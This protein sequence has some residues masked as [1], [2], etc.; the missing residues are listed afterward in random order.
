MGQDM[1]RVTIIGYVTIETDS[2]GTYAVQ[3]DAAGVARLFARWQRTDMQDVMTYGV[4]WVYGIR[5]GG[6]LTDVLTPWVT[7]ASQEP[8]VLAR[9]AERNVYPGGRTY[10]VE[11][12][13]PDGVRV[14]SVVYL[15]PHGRTSM[16]FEPVEKSAN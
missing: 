4:P 13:H 10:R 8:S 2:D 12:R 1:N 15:D 16:V 3:A 5:E 7:D 14:S 9:L 6:S 11:I